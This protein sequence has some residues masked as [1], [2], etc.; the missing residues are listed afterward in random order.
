MSNLIANKKYIED[1]LLSGR[2]AILAT[3]GK[4]Q[5]HM[6]LIAITPV[7][8][9]RKLLFSTYRNTVKYSN[10]IENGKVAVLIENGD[11]KNLSLQGNFILTAFGHAE[12][13]NA[14]NDSILKLHLERHPDM[15][16]FMQSEE[17][18]LIQITLNSFQLVLGIE[19]VYWYSLDDLDSV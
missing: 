14:G 15:K 1:A 9:Y 3:E 11:C 13:I 16:S 6:S 19:D 12:E 18:A 10:L 7:G 2:F 4:G 17:C 5:P 8:A